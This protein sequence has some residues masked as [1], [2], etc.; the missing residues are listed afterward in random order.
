MKSKDT[1]DGEELICVA[2]FTCTGL[3]TLEC[4]KLSKKVLIYLCVQNLWKTGVR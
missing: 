3:K 2:S 1:I 4:P